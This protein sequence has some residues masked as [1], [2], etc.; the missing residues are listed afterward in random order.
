VVEGVVVFVLVFCAAA[1]DTNPRASTK[2][3]PE[4]NPFALISMTN[5]RHDRAILPLRSIV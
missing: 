5:L 4:R 1:A 3:I 2:N